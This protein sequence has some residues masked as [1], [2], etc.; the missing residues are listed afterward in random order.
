MAFCP[1]VLV[2]GSDLGGWRGDREFSAL[3]WRF[4]ALCWWEGVIWV[5]GEEIG[6]L[7]PWG[8]VS[9]APWGEGDGRSK[10]RLCLDHSSGI[11]RS[12]LCLRF[13]KN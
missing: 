2:G 10:L 12:A 1:T 8:G 5:V 3:G 9:P 6:N 4:A 13:L 7:V 11:R